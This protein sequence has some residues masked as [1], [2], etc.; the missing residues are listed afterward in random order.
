M[1]DLRGRQGACAHTS[2]DPNDSISSR[3]IETC[4]RV[5]SKGTL[6]DDEKT[7]F[8]ITTVTDLPNT[9]SADTGEW[10]VETAFN[11]TSTGKRM[12]SK[13]WPPEL[14]CDVGGVAGRCESSSIDLTRWPD[15]FSPGT[16]TFTYTLGL[17]T[18]KVVVNTITLGTT[19]TTVPTGPGAPR[20]PWPWTKAYAFNLSCVLNMRGSDV[21]GRPYGQIDSICECITWNVQDRYRADQG[22]DASINDELRGIGSAC[23]KKVSEL[24]APQQ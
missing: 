20:Y 14:S 3:S 16:Y 7:P 5:G 13:H 23:G 6:S 15:A 4:L 18:S 17:D 22:A 1:T 11:G 9:H 8:V 10:Q 12:M 2:L 21:T 19:G 24:G